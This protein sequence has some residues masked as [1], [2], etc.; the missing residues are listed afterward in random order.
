M[1][2]LLVAN[3]IP[4]SQ[5]SMQR[6]AAMLQHGLLEAKHQVRVIRP[7]V[8]AGK[9]PARGLAAKWLGYV[10]KLLFFPGILRRA[11][12]WADVI[13][14]CDHSN[15]LYVR[16]LKGRV[17]IVTCHDLLA[18]RSALGEITQQSTGWTGCRL[19]RMI[20]DGLKAAQ[21]VVCVSDAT[22]RDLL[23]VA[24]VGE[25]KT[26]RI[27]NGHNYA[28]APMERAQAEARLLRL[29]IA[30]DVVFVL[31]VG[32]NQWYKNRLGVL[33]MFSLLCKRPEM[34]NLRLVMVGKPWTVEMRR[35]AQRLE[36]EH[37]VN[38][39]VSIGEEDLRALYSCASMLLFPSLE[40][41]FGWPII[42]AQA[43]GCPVVTS[44]RQPMTEVGGGAARYIDPE[45]ADSAVK[46]MIDVLQSP[47]EFR[48]R[49][50]LNAARFSTAQAIQGYL[51]I[52]KRV[53]RQIQ[54]TPAAEELDPSPRVPSAV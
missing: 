51:E 18:V 53:S 9:V 27:Y 52:Y 31:H 1:K 39:L 36:I 42:E 37:S 14:I 49:G 50:L 7:P 2:I 8:V 29:G 23:R 46:E 40:E 16:H 11:A 5:E 25:D 24:R 54:P 43:C 22:R 45:N 17:H 4:D 21:H 48:E 28:Y 44:G 38:E 19:Q 33:Q 32:G 26:S 41:G 12:Q 34:R 13:H 30:S 35:L 20:L 15:S 3:Y 6:F 10:D 47:S